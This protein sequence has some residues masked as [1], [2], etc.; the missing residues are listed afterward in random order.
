M[1][2]NRYPNVFFTDYGSSDYN[3][4]LNPYVLEEYDPSHNVLAQWRRVSGS[5]L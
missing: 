5:D 2:Y 1:E 4:G 3:L